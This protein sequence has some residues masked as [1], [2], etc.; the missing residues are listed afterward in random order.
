VLDTLDTVRLE[1]EPA[2]PA[3]EPAQDAE[4]NPLDQAYEWTICIIILILIFLSVMFEQMKD[5]VEEWA[6]ADSQEIVAQ[7]FAELTVLGF[8]GLLTFLAVQSDMLSGISDSLFDN[9]DAVEEILETLHFNLFFVMCFF[10]GE[11]VCLIIAGKHNTVRWKLMER[12]KLYEQ[13]AH[14]LM[15]IGSD[16][17]SVAQKIKWKM[18]GLFDSADVD[19][20]G[21]LDATELKNFPQPTQECADFRWMRLTWIMMA[22]SHTMNLLRQCATVAS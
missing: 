17:V 10:I 11:V 8:L 4:V 5:I 15:I 12:A 16:E 22:K 7:T 13:K 6:G 19:G 14:E 3:P 18:H 21:C 2:A 20:S 9:E 1:T